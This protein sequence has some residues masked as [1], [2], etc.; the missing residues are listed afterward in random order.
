MPGLRAAIDRDDYLI[1]VDAEQRYVLVGGIRS[2]GL[3]AG[4]AIAEHVTGLLGEAGLDLTERAGS[5]RAAADAEPRRG[6]GA[7]VPGRRAH[8]RRPGVRPVVCFCERVTAGE[9][10][11]ACH[12]PSRQPTSTGCAG[13]PAR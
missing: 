11:D 1:D 5:A 7:P 2:T 12:P 8:R 3:T 13:A 9:I 6:R 4:M 10:R